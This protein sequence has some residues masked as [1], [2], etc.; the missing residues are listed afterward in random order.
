LERR[1]E[2]NF[3]GKTRKMLQEGNSKFFE[4]LEVNDIFESQLLNEEYKIWKK[5]TPFLYD[6]VI[7]YLLEWPSATIEWLPI[8]EIGEDPDFKLNKL[9]MGTHTTN[10]DPNYLMIAKV[11]RTP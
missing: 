3:D 5:N 6:L 4:K 11:A 10:N 1:I 2:I 7:T 9:V 8:F